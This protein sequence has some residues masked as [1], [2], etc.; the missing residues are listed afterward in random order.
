MKS[1]EYFDS[2]RSITNQTKQ[3]DNKMCS[4][5]MFTLHGQYGMEVSFAFSMDIEGINE[6]R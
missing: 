6:A 1:R 4:L 2:D 3:S 5:L